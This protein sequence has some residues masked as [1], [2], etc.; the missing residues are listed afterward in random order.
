MIRTL[1]V[2]ATVAVLSVGGISPAKAE[3]LANSVGSFLD[4]YHVPFPPPVLPLTSLYVQFE[5]AAAPVR[6][7]DIILQPPHVGADRGPQLQLPQQIEVTKL[8]RTARAFSIYDLNGD[9]WLDRSELTQ[10]L[11]AWALTAE[12]GKPFGKASYFYASESGML[13][14]NRFLLNYDDSSYVRRS[15]V[16]RGHGGSADLLNIIDEES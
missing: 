13:P 14:M 16:M 1:L 8:V 11:L 3:G 7:I 9:D 15:I 6:V 5:G 10:G 2:C 4:N 12:A